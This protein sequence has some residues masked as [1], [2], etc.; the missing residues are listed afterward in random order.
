MLMLRKL[1]SANMSLIYL[2][3]VFRFCFVDLIIINAV[4]IDSIN[5]FKNVSQVI[6]NTNL[7]LY[8]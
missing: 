4:N 1:L 7:Y 5:Y 2:I 8:F 6:K 3:N